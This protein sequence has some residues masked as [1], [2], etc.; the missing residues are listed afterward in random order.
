MRVPGDEAEE[1][2]AKVTAMSVQEG[3][4]RDYASARALFLAQCR[5][6]DLAVSSYRHPRPGPD[7]A[8]IYCDAARV[9]PSG[10]ARAL[11][12][13]SGNH[14]VEGYAGSNAQVALIEGLA[15]EGLPAD[16][17][18]LLIHMLN[19]WGAAWR[20]RHTH[21][22]VDLNRS[23]VDRTTALPA[24]AAHAALVDDGFIDCLRAPTPEEALLA[25]S[26]FRRDHGDEIYAQAVF[27]GQYDH[28]MGLGYGGGA[29]SWSHDA[30]RRAVDDLLG[31]PD[32]VALIDLHTGLGPFGVGTVICT[33]PPGSAELSPLRAWYDDH[34]V[35]LLE[36]R[37]G[38]P[39]RLQ[40]DLAHGVRQVLPAARLLPISLEFGTYD[41]DRFAALMIKD[42]WA[43]MRSDPEDPEVEAIRCDLM[44][45]FYPRSAFWRRLIAQRTMSVATMA[46]AGLRAL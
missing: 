45:F 25:V 14:G 5:R 27:Q 38:L 20:R 3:F 2:S 44:H 43:E 34:F 22:N 29:A 33:E 30:L 37:Q 16:I 11:V 35:A 42:A 7:G 6:L 21:D 46:L 13:V 4:A 39:Y 40:G 32:L 24:N 26:R 8:P 1:H 10:A 28:P 23:F 36:D 31:S 9:G 12:V 18:I 15:R 41:A 17:S 19:P